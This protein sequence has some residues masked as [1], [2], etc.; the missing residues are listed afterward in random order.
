[1]AA[2]QLNAV[3]IEPVGTR[4]FPIDK[5][6]VG[7]I[8]FVCKRRRRI[9]RN[10]NIEAH[11]NPAPVILEITAQAPGLS[12]EEMERY[13]TR[14]MEIGLY[15][16][17]GIQAIR[18]VLQGKPCFSADIA[19]MMA[20]RLVEGKLPA[21]TSPDELLNKRELEVFHLLGRGCDTRQIAEQ[22]HISYRT[23]Q[24]F[25]ARIKEKLKIDP[26]HRTAAR[27]HA[28][29]RQPAQNMI[30]A[31]K[32]RMPSH[33]R[34]E[35]TLQDMP[36]TPVKIIKDSWRKLAPRNACKG[37]ETKFFFWQGRP[38]GTPGRLGEASLPCVRRILSHTRAQN[39][40]EFGLD[41]SHAA[42]VTWN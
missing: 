3:K 24:S 20:E 7:N 39:G 40:Q 29:E 36:P 41:M 33:K 37:C 21:T 30:Q 2:S 13:Y 10:L 5:E 18:S 8:D 12:A 17:P 15:T 38:A 19:A 28:L 11:P 14:T 9:Y 22:I 27:S 1:M 42:V 23:V 26:C 34:I 35:R 4:L 25:C 32:S 6:A 31:N 16:T